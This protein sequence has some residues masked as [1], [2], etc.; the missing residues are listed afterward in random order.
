MAAIIT[1]LTD[2]GQRDSYVAE[3][4]GVLLCALPTAQIVDITHGIPR[5][6]VF[7][8]QYVLGRTW[9]RFP[10]GTVHLVVV[11][12]GVGSERRAIAALNGEHRFI[13]PDNGVLTPVLAAATVFELPVSANAA[14]TFHGRDV[15]APMAAI[16][17]AGTPLERAG[18]EIRD[19]VLRPLPAA[20]QDG[21]DL[22][23]VVIYV[24][25]FGTLVTNLD[26]K[27]AAWAAKAARA[28]KGG[29]AKKSADRPAVAERETVVAVAG[30]VA[31]L[32]RTFTDVAS[33]ELVAFV[34]SGGTIEIAVRNG[35][36]AE[37]L[38]VRDGAEA[39]VRS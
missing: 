21:T 2:F 25:G 24:D 10:N 30:R 23:G 32:M 13:G 4:K 17:A 39:R 35:S 29:K 26:A 14:P 28:V 9:Q 22:V 6:N 11:D 36:A 8:A 37:V 31:P 18:R 19:P 15:F 34:G 38:G 3:M 27:A 7:A 20:R 33:G 12:P 1:L 16:L 5:G